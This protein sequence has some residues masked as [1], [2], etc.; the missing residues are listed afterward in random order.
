MG[1]FDFV[2]K[3]NPLLVLREDLSESPGFAGFIPHEQL[4]AVQVQEFRHI[5]TKQVSRRRKGN[6]KAPAPTPSSLPRSRGETGANQAASRRAAIRV[7]RA[8]AC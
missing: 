8:R 5:E 7:D 4:R 6:A 1:L 2:E 3:Q